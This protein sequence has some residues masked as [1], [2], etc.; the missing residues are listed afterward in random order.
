MSA[1]LQ[2]ASQSL[3]AE[4]ERFPWLRAV[5]IGLVDGSA[6][7]F[8]YVSRNNKEVRQQIPEQWEGFPVT[9][10]KMSQPIPR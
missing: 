10:R 9:A 6:G 2:Q 8:V 7:I 4:L 5:G 3:H 1:E